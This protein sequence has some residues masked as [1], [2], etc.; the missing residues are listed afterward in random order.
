MSSNVHRV[1]VLA[2]IDLY[3]I[4]ISSEAGVLSGL[5]DN[6][7]GASSIDIN[8]AC[9]AG[10]YERRTFTDGECMCWLGNAV[11]KG[12]SDTETKSEERANER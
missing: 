10:E 12:P 5:D 3:V 6:A 4:E 7:I 1:A 8:R 2:V 11:S 9:I